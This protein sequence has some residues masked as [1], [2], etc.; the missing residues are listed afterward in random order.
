MTLL[1][2]NDLSDYHITIEEMSIRPVLL[3][4]K[5]EGVE[6]QDEQQTLFAT[7]GVHWF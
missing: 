4:I 2:V 3:G 7:R 6:V 1:A 5:L